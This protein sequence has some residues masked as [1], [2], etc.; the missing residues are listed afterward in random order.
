MI[1]LGEV[2]LATPSL[3]C[4]VPFDHDQSA[5]VGDD[6]T[7][8]LQL[9]PSLTIQRCDTAMAKFANHKQSHTAT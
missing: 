1:K 7:L 4:N 8:H 9:C 3:Q 6:P 2:R 5:A